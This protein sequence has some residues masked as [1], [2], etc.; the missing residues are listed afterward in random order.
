MFVWSLRLFFYLV[1]LS[2][3]PFPSSVSHCH[4]VFFEI[5]FLRGW[6]FFFLVCSY[7]VGLTHV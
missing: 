3:F 1:G 6:S 7:L 2:F 4:G 5:S